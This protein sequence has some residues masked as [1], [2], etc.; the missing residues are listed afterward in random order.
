MPQIINRDPK[1]SPSKPAT[2]QSAAAAKGRAP[3]HDRRGISVN[4]VV[5]AGAVALLLIV[6]LF[7]VY[8]H[9][10]TA[11]VREAHKVAPLPGMPDTPPYNVKEWQDMYKSGKATFVSG[12]PH[13]ASTPTSG[14]G[15]GKP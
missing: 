15:T 14:G 2:N 3:S 12:V 5:A 11:P 9:P 4:V 10:F 1:S 8:V 7:H 6:Y 13:V